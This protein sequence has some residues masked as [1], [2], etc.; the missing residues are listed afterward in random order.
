MTWNGTWHPLAERFP[1]LTE[2]EIREMAASIKERGQYVPC[3]VAPDGVGLD[4]R[5]RVAACALVEAEPWW[6]VYEGEP[7]PFIVEVNAERR[8]LTVGQRAMAVA[9]GWMES[10]QRENGR[11]TRGTRPRDK[12]GAGL[13]SKNAMHYSG[14]VLD[15]APELA[16]A[17]LRGDVSLEVAYKQADDLR[18][19]KE[20]MAALGDDNAKLVES[21]VITLE[22]AERRIEEEARM[23]LLAA[24]LV[25]RVNSEN[26]SLEE[27]EA[28]M[29]E[30]RVRIA[31]TVQEIRRA[32][33]VL[34][35]MAGRPIPEEITEALQEGEQ[36][37]LTQLL[38]GVIR[39]D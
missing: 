20:R 26:L 28:I 8:H 25:E 1:M 2:D 22:E 35:P 3:R 33:E 7:I 23:A 31:E 39:N 38:E 29:A 14:V 9:I 18:K 15:H 36:V 5:N 21:E 11:W 27:A 12:S 4:G 17:V 13:I 19:R 30:R 24:D 37:T 10:G 32:M 16:D 34:Q 6:E